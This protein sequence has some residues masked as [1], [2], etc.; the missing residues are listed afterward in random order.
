MPLIY[1]KRPLYPKDLRGIRAA[2]KGIKRIIHPDLKNRFG[3]LV[4]S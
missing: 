2:S 4:L 3:G 1:V